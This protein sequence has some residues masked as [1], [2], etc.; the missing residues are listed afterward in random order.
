MLSSCRILPVAVLAV[1]MATLLRAD[2]DLIRGLIRG[3]RF[4]DAIA[5]CD[6]ELNAAPG[7]FPLYTMK[8]LALQGSGNQAESLTAF[9]RALAINPHYQP[10][11]QAAAQIE[12][13]NKD[14]NAIKTLE[15][16][17]RGDPASET[18]HAMMAAL[19]FERRSCGGALVHFEKAGTTLQAPAVKWQYAVCL[20]DRQRWG[21]AAKQFAS[22]LQ[23]REYAPARYNL[24]LAY[25][26]AKDYPAAVTALL[27]MERAGADAD[28]MRLLAGALE[29][30]GDTRKAIAVLQNAIRQNPRDEPLLIDLAVTCM[31]HKAL[32]LALEVIQAGIQ[33]APSSPKLQTLL[34]VVLVRR[35]DV[36]GGRDAFQK[37]QQLA[38]ESGL[39]GIGLASV[40][41]QM[42]L[43]SDAV[44]L[45]REQLTTGAGD[46][47]T[48][49]TLVRALLLKSPSTEEK[50]EAVM[51]LRKIIAGE[52][53]NGAAHGLLGK[54]YFQSGEI[55][56]SVTELQAAI[57]LDP[58]DRNSAY[59]LMTLYRRA[60]K[61]ADASE[62]A[63]RIRS[64]LEKESA[65]E[66]A[67]NR[68]QL[69][70]EN[71]SSGE[72][73]GGFTLRGPS[74]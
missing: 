52:P 37:A 30:T 7:S 41:M 24:A 59:Q 61:S 69:V 20:M 26:S 53:G 34:G 40:M 50:K 31:D 73:V 56:K 3:G 22:L 74:R 71:G 1:L 27:P 48:E 68:F 62:L 29:A 45:L 10:A 15:A 18:A 25:W 4:A 57:R 11:L 14:A 65:D 64:S 67:A 49:L 13:Q 42:G 51:L 66:D 55:A 2:L 38:P 36:T 9:R 46:T 6:R 32:D 33:L 19:L 21:D 16:V 8:G 17:L 5:E 12:F 47:R 44:M 72:A 58:A 28:A 39:G 70:R 63:R 35:G 23:F 43:A 54:V 60:G